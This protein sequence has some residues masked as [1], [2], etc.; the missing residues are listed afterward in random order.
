MDSKRLLNSAQLVAEL[1]AR[2]GGTSPIGRST[3]DKDRVSKR[4]IPFYDFDGRAFYDPDEVIAA[5][6]RVR[7][8]G[9]VPV[10]RRRRE[11]TDATR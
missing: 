6:T 4:R 5:L 2:N 3:L 1:R 7:R 9:D 8:G 10:H 11:A